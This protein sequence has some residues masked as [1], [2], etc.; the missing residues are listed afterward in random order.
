MFSKETYYL[1]IGTEMGYKADRP[2]TVEATDADLAAADDEYAPMDLREDGKVPTW[3]VKKGTVVDV[4]VLL[5]EKV[6]YPL[7]ET[8]GLVP[9]SQ[10]C[11][12]VELDATGP[13]DAPV[14]HPV[15]VVHTSW[16]GLSNE[17]LIALDQD[18]NSAEY[19]EFSTVLTTT[20][21]GLDV[22]QLDNLKRCTQ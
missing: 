11:D 8:N 21:P 1:G 22:A 16:L 10:V 13:H 20:L 2:Q 18:E 19:K 9:P 5:T 12:W 15:H 17:D 4:Q 7:P 6:P 14:E 3:V